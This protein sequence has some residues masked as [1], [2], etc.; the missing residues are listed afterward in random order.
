MLM[1][2]TL[3]CFAL[4]LGFQLLYINA[5]TCHILRLAY[6]VLILATPGAQIYSSH[7]NAALEFCD[8]DLQHA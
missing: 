1:L 5:H 3:T 7:I 4:W 2:A 8:R 6:P